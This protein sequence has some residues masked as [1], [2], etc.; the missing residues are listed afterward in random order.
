MKKIIIILTVMLLLSACQERDL[1]AADTPEPIITPAPV[2][3]TEAIITTTTPAPEI[4]TE[5]EQIEVQGSTERW[6]ST[7]NKTIGDW[8]YI[9][10]QVQMTEETTDGTI[11]YGI[12][13]VT[14]VNENGESE[15]VISDTYGYIGNIDSDG[16]W[17]Y[18]N[19]VN[20]GSDKSTDGIFRIRPDGTENQVIIYESNILFKVVD[21][22]LYYINI[23]FDGVT[24][25]LY[26]GSETMDDLPEFG[27]FRIRL[28]AT[29]ESEEASVEKIAGLGYFHG[30]DVVFHSTVTDFDVE[31]DWIYFVERTS[32]DWKTGIYK[33]HVNGGD[34]QLIRDV[35]EEGASG[36]NVVDNY[37]YFASFDDEN[38]EFNTGIYR[39]NM[40]GTDKTLITE[41]VF[42]W[43][44]GGGFRYRVDVDNGWIYY[45]SHDYDNHDYYRYKIRLDG[46]EKQQVS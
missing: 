1:Q 35:T 34:P 10:E 16:D 29:D 40:E 7:R 15:A 25:D 42:P 5:P 37:I 3:T 4:T 36:L 26:T 18:Y 39:I 43:F 2:I 19:I 23:G 12:S 46:T 13:N 17:V 6:R 44:G 27:L 20:Y 11:Y 31:G 28:E 45:N 22:W 30:H 32:A 8:T 33:I 21:G 24:Y 14:R 38:G 41:V 9:I